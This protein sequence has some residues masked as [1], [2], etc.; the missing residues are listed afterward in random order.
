MYEHSWD[1]HQLP[2][3]PRPAPGLP[4]DAEVRGGPAAPGDG[5]PET[6]TGGGGPGPGHRPA[7]SE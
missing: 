2:V 1:L 5:K 3:G 6:G 7:V 4:G